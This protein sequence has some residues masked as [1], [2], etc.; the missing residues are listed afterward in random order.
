[1]HFDILLTC[2]IGRKSEKP[3]TRAMRMAHEY[4]VIHCIN[5][6]NY[7]ARTWPAYIYMRMLAPA[8]ARPRALLAGHI[9]WAGYDDVITSSM[10][11]MRSERAVCGHDSAG[12]S[13]ISR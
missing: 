5:F 7:C 6:I 10:R 12:S 1:M 8:L 13:S 3:T 4:C 2:V 9:M 11:D